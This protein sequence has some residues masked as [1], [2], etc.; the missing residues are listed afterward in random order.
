ML[1]FDIETRA[2]ALGQ[3]ERV[4]GAFDSESFDL[5]SLTVDELRLYADK[6]EGGAPPKGARKDVIIQFVQER[7]EVLEAVLLHAKAKY[8]EFIVEKAALHAET[9]E[10]LAIGFQTPE[11]GFAWRGL[12]SATEK[13]LIE[14]FWQ[15]CWAE[16]TQGEQIIG[17]NILE[18]DLP[19]LVR[20]SYMLRVPVPECVRDGRYWSSNFVDLLNVWR[21]GQ[22]REWITLDRMARAF[23]IGSKNGSGKDFAKLWDDDRDQAKVYLQNDLYLTYS[24]AERMGFKA[25]VKESTILDGKGVA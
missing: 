25:S 21:A 6:A 19:Y 10:V 4:C 22:Y 13:E 23:G 3:I 11:C 17:F 2:L 1:V 14:G 20:R 12:D 5:S 16:I 24:L 7:D 18:F 15:D 9:S 8:L